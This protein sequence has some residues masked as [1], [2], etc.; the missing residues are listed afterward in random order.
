[1]SPWLVVDANGRAMSFRGRIVIGITGASGSIY[2]I[3]L[4]EV[5]SAFPGAEIHLVITEA[6]KT[7][8]GLETT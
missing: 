3:R 6:G 1:V 2:G 5:L 8:I 4:L 7:T